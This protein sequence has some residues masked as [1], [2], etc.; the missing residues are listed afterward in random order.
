MFVS[1]GIRDTP[2][3]FFNVFNHCVACLFYRRG[4]GSSETDSSKV[5]RPVNHSFVRSCSDFLAL[6]FLFAQRHRWLQCGSVGRGAKGV[7]PLSEAS[8]AVQQGGFRKGLY[9][10]C[11][12]ISGQDPQGPTRSLTFQKAN[13]WGARGQKLEVPGTLD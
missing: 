1:T 3:L 8:E 13:I 11:I 5:K 12:L 10:R 6:C 4:N 7:R 9:L 2:A